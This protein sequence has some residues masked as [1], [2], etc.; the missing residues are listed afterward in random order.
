[1]IGERHNV[2]FLVGVIVGAAVSAVGTLFFTPLSGAETRQ[3]VTGRVAALRGDGGG[4]DPP[5]PISR[6]EP[7]DTAAGAPTPVFT[8]ERT[9]ASDR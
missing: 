6:L 3:Q 2:A 8:L 7:H 9:D 4:V 1:M 5:A